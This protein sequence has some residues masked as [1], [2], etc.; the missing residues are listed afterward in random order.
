[1]T[2]SVCKCATIRLGFSLTS[3]MKPLAF[4]CDCGLGWGGDETPN[5]R[6]CLY[7]FLNR[8]GTKK[9]TL[10]TQTHSYVGKL[11]HT[12]SN[13][14]VYSPTT[15]PEDKSKWFIVPTDLLDKCRCLIKVAQVLLSFVAFILE[16]VV[17]SCSQCS[18][19]Y[20]FEFVSCT[21]FLFTALLLILLSTN[22]HKKVGVDCWPALDFLYTVGI[23]LFFLVASI[24]F[25]SG[26][27]GTDLEKTAVV[28]GFMA[29]IAFL[30]D[31]GWFV[32]TRGFPFKKTNQP[33]SNNVN[34][35]PP[36]AEKLNSDG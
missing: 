10:K 33:S 15:V 22:L 18:R 5:L 21:A 11:R 34:G 28:F 13:T 29:T 9:T 17:T 30:F 1:M 24:V 31:A 8:N 27:G 26:N 4:L 3:T 20:F 32:K 14:G 12:M 2:P 6:K 35:T 7:R 19:L 36:E 25:S 16:E 23:G